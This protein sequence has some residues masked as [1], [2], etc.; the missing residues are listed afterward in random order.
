MAPREGVLIG[1]SANDVRAAR[2][3]G[4]GV[5]CVTYG[6]NHGNDIRDSAPDAVLDSLADLPG[7]FVSPR[8][9]RSAG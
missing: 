7:V 1:D 4:F 8:A 2:A 9:A 3:A 6:Y 5:V